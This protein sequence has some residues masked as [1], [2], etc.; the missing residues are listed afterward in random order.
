MQSTGKRRFP[1]FFLVGDNGAEVRMSF[2]RKWHMEYSGADLHFAFSAY[3]YLPS[4]ADNDMALEPHC[5]VKI[6]SGR[7]SRPLEP[8]SRLLRT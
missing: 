5:S 3:R 6:R 7:L 4:G 1:L 8:A 2:A